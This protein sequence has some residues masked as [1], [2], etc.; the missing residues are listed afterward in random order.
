MTIVFNKT[1]IESSYHNQ[2]F[3]LLLF[4]LKYNVLRLPIKLESKKLNTNKETK[5]IHHSQ[6]TQN[7]K[8]MTMHNEVDQ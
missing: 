2:N 3:H 5:C 1:N 4:Y 6:Y 8:I 7:A